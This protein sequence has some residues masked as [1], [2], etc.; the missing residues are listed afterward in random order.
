M[1]KQERNRIACKKYN[2]ANKA[3]A[4]A[5]REANRDKAA[6]YRKE[7]KESISDYARKYNKTHR[8][9]QKDGLVTV[10]LLPKENYVGQTVNLHRRLLEHKNRLGR[11]I[12]DAKVL[13]K[14]KTL[15]EALAVE[16]SYHA[17]GY[18][19]NKKLQ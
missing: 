5:Y 18:L 6:T 8:E 13:G 2:D 11:C 1:T 15:Q 7:N 19:G 4:A 3:K 17:K 10:Y 16:A 12:I 9:S 14:Y